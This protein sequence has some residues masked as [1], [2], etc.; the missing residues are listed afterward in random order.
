[1][2]FQPS[3]RLKF[4]TFPRGSMP[5]NPPSQGMLVRSRPV[6]PWHSPADYALCA[7][8]FFGTEHKEMVAKDDQDELM[9]LLKYEKRELYRNE[10][11]AGSLRWCFGISSFHTTRIYS[12]L[13]SDQWMQIS[14]SVNLRIAM[15]DTLTDH[16]AETW[17]PFQLR[18]KGGVGVILVL[19]CFV[20]GGWVI[21][22]QRALGGWLYNACTVLQNCRPPLT[23]NKRPALRVRGCDRPIRTNRARFKR[24][25]VHKLWGGWKRSDVPN[26]TKK[27][28]HQMKGTHHSRANHLHGQLDA[29]TCE[30][31]I[32]ASAIA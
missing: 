30:R 31:R 1:M 17:G 20:V 16:G 18:R 22:P 32:C 7:D 2:H 8:W 27:N 24:R 9:Q 23:G 19:T 5:P 25:I 15:R 14:E 29:S 13:Y 28:V 11:G 12:L 26:T 6:S 4:Q 3:K 10:F 21:K